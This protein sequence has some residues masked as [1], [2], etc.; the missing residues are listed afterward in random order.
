MPL[1][2]EEEFSALA[3][4]YPS[5]QNEWEHRFKGTG[6][7]PRLVLQDI[8]TDPQVLRYKCKTLVSINSEINSRTKIAQ[9]LI[10][11]HSQ[12]PYRQYDVVYASELAMQ[13]ISR[14]KLVLNRRNMET[15]LARAMEI[16]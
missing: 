16:R 12:A 10:P 6:G 4:L 3:R 8:E 15:F 14:T 11:I 1:W 13:V 9:T 5:A 2:T 7:V